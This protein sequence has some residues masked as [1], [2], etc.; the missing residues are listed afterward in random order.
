MTE[1]GALLR[2][3]ACP[4]PEAPELTSHPQ[5]RIQRASPE[6][7]VLPRRGCEVQRRFRTH[8]RRRVLAE[9]NLPTQ[10]YRA[11]T[12]ARLPRADENG[13]GPEGL[14]PAARQGPQAPLSLGPARP[15]PVP[16]ERLRRRS[17][18][19]RVARGRKWVTPGVIVQARP[20]PIESA[21]D[22]KNKPLPS[23]RVGFTVTKKV[24]N[25]TV[26]NRARRRLRAAADRLLPAHGR[27]GNDIVL[28]G[29]RATLDRPFTA[30]VDDLETALRRLKVWRKGN[31]RAE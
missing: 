18:F 22:Q 20:T 11:Q 28:I 24:G 2:L 15:M 23:M 16:V 9:K 17:D 8:S 3:P 13:G 31:A 12:A 19:L 27:P 25:A 26:R 10:H 29:R 7:P 6:G 5:K 30:L 1:N 21:P 4:P 14:G